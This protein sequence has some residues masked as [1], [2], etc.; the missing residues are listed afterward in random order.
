MSIVTAVVSKTEASE[1]LFLVRIVSI[2]IE[3]KELIVEMVDNG[4]TV[5]NSKE[6]LIYKFESV[7][8]SII[9]EKSI[10]KGEVIRV[11]GK[12]DRISGIAIIS[13]RI[14]G[15]SNKIGEYDPT[16]VRKRLKK[17]IDIHGPP[18]RGMLRGGR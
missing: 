18:I 3:Q 12:I 13:G 16:G 10:K 8:E 5:Q 6:K 1:E 9:Q 11:W 7:P 15:Q 14:A 17:R 2:N 4:R